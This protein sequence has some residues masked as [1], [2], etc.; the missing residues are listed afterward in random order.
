MRYEPLSSLYYHGPENY[1]EAYRARFHSES[2]CHLDFSIGD[3]PAFFLITNETLS[4]LASIYK[5]DKQLTRLR[6]ELPGAAIEQFLQNSLIEEVMLTNGIEGVHST[7]REVEDA[8]EALRQNDKRK[9]FQG[10]VQKYDLLRTSDSIPLRAPE[11]VRR[12]YDELVLEEVLREDPEDK[13]DGVLFRKESTSVTSQTGKTIHRGVYPEAE[14]IHRMEQAL[15]FLNAEEQNALIR[16]SVF[17]YLFGYIHPFYN[18]NGRTSRFISS[19]LIT[20]EL[21]PL[22]GYR[23]SYT[24]KG[25]INTYYKAFKLCNDPKN[26][27]DLTPFLLMFLTM[28][29]SSV[30]E[31]VAAL[32]KRFHRWCYYCDLCREL[33][34]ADEKSFP[35]Y[36]LL[37]QASLF[38]SKGLSKDMMCQILEISRPTLTTRLNGMQPPDLLSVTTEDHKKYYSLN[39][40]FLDGMAQ[41]ESP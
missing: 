7:R 28:I 9:R 34:H 40:S 24:I 35:L 19:Y 6:G 10:L 23:L 13:P 33:L 11:D 1:S 38:A 17:H 25:S 15:R 8:L 31:L 2:A 12:L 5:A 37:V 30:K 36:S 29:D 41:E 22:V 4:L 27:G 16:L 3:S 18:G 14:I 26:K 32:E 21:D 39:L 20:K